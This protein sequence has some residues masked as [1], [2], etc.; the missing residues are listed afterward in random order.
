MEQIETNQQWRGFKSPGVA[1]ETQLCGITLWFRETGPGTFSMPPRAGSGKAQTSSSSLNDPV[2]LP[3]TVDSINV[4]GTESD[5]FLRN[6]NRHLFCLCIHQ[7]QNIQKYLNA[8]AIYSFRKI[9]PLV[10]MWWASSFQK[11]L[12]FF[13]SVSI[14]PPPRRFIFKFP[15]TEWVLSTLRP[16]VIIFISAA[17]HPKAWTSKCS[18]ICTLTESGVRVHTKHCGLQHTHD[19]YFKSNLNIFLLQKCFWAPAK[20]PFTWSSIL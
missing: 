16:E 13:L 1:K 2:F 5:V 10:N 14:H 9:K 18:I 15:I 3:H 20:S 7:E 17:G 8:H 12:Q 4:L 6:G 11:P 19:T